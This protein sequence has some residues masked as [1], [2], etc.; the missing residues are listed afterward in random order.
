MAA[1]KNKRKR[2]RGGNRG[3]S[4]SLNCWES[5]RL[6]QNICLKRTLVRF[7]AFKFFA[8]APPG[9]RRR[10]WGAHH[11]WTPRSPVTLARGVVVARVLLASDVANLCAAVRAAVHR[12]AVGRRPANVGARVRATCTLVRATGARAPV[13]PGAASAVCRAVGVGGAVVAAAAAT[14]VGAT[15]GGPAA[16]RARCPAPVPRAAAQR[17]AVRRPPRRCLLLLR[18]RRPPPPLARRRRPSSTRPHARP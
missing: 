13:P 2:T 15:R 10:R 14:G 12:G 17:R 1:P 7:G 5:G 18:R 8:A 4:A 9:W 16:A 6:Y 3:A 11:K